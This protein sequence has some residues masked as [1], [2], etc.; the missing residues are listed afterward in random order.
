MQIITKNAGGEADDY[1]DVLEAGFAEGATDS[2]LVMMF[3]RELSAGTWEGD[4]NTDDYFS[5]SYCI[6]LRLGETVYGGLEQVAFFGNHGTFSF[7][8]GAAQVLGT[9]RQ[10]VV[11]FQVSERNL[12]EF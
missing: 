12:W 9:G 10:V 8:E 5:N 1:Y 4:P 2:D 7:L 6:T 11:D 3:Q